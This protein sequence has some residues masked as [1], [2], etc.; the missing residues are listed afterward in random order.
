MWSA[1][2][3]WTALLPVD[4]IKIDRSFVNRLNNT[5][6]GQN[7]VRAIVDLARNTGLHVVAEGIETEEQAT[8]LLQL[9]CEY[10]QGHLF[11]RSLLLSALEMR[12]N[13]TLV[14]TSHDANAPPTRPLKPA[15]T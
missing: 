2:T 1:T 4:G 10:G 15:L 8:S 7:I 6:N 5:R 12:L 3:P 9:H 11:D 14:T 13:D